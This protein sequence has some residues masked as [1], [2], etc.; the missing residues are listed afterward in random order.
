MIRTCCARHAS[1]DADDEMMQM[2]EL[3]R[4][5]WLIENGHVGYHYHCPLGDPFAGTQ[6]IGEHEGKPALFD[7]DKNF[8]ENITNCPKC[9]QELTIKDN[10][11]IPN[12]W[13]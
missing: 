10:S 11:G 12:H 3:N 2:D 8:I 7:K 6:H 4:V 5:E 9:G 13:A 1:V